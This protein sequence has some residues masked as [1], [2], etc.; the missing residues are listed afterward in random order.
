MKTVRVGI[1]VPRYIEIEV[2]DD[3]HEDDIVDDDGWA[4]RYM[5]EVEY[6][7]LGHV[8][9]ESVRILEDIIAFGLTDEARV[10]LGLS[11]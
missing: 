7:I 1:S 10:R 2:D 3:A 5:E 4:G 11:C 9:I 8:Q 6:K